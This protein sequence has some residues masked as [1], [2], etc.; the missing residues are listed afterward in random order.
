ME[1]NWISV[2][3][4]GSTVS[5]MPNTWLLSLTDSLQ[6]FVLIS[7]VYFRHFFFFFFRI[8]ENCSSQLVSCY[9]CSFYTVFIYMPKYS[10][11]NVHV[12]QLVKHKV[13]VKPKGKGKPSGFKGM[14]SKIKHSVF[15]FHVVFLW[16]LRNTSGEGNGTPLQY[17]CLENRMDRGAW[18]AAVHWVA[19][20]WTWLSNF[21]FTFHF[22][23]LEKEM[24]THSSVLAWRIPRTGEPWRLPSM[25]SHRVRH[26]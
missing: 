8:L 12:K 9:H 2:I 19:K 5:Y 22:P 3:S 25:G 16:K 13:S 11:G 6:N 23:A 20:S 15:A 1:L 4:V 18:W 26:D 10:L 21:T 7:V 14:K 17:S 24:A